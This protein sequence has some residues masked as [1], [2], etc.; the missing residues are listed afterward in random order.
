MQPFA[1]AKPPKQRVT[2]I[3]FDHPSVSDIALNEALITYLHSVG[4][5]ESAEMTKERQR[6]LTLLN[7]CIRRWGTEIWIKKGL[8][9]EKSHDTSPKLFAFGSYRLGVHDPNADLDTLCIIPQHIEREDFFSSLFDILRNE[10]QITSVIPVVNA[11]VPVMMLEICGISIDLT[12][13]R[14]QQTTIPQDL[15]LSHPNILLKCVD[16]T[17]R[18]SL[19]GPR[20]TDEILTL[21]PAVES[22]RMALR[23]IKRWAKSRAI[24]SNSLG[25]PGGVSWAML[26]AHI[27]QFYPNAAAATVLCKFFKM[28]T[29][30][31]WPSPVL[32]TDIQIGGQFGS[33]VWCQRNADKQALMPVITPTYPAFNST[34][35]ISL[36]T[37]SVLLKEFQRGFAITSAIEKGTM[38][39]SD[40]FEK[41]SFFHA[42]NVFIRINCIAPNKE[43]FNKLTGLV[44]SR[45]RFMVAKLDST[46][47]VSYAHPYSNHIG[48]KNDE[49]PT[50]ENCAY[51]LGLVYKEGVKQIT[52]TQ[53]VTF[54]KAK[55]EEHKAPSAEVTVQVLTKYQLPDWCFENGV[56][57][58]PP[59][60]KKR[61]PKAEP[62][63]ATNTATAPKKAK[64]AE[65]MN[66]DAPTHA[67]API[68]RP[69]DVALPLPVNNVNVESDSTDHV[70]VDPS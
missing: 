23:S 42:Y 8:P 4:T 3:T 14:L 55:V 21:V 27:C 6:V 28:Y 19:N 30:W 62:V 16:A 60:K 67:L 45:I 22:F 5:F 37:K 46:E 63:D 12:C 64:L 9:N 24:Y 59:T 70:Q 33:E 35:N 51:F 53:A 44:E 25:F 34:F 29:Q 11:K 17:D 52:I 69:L 1:N 2:P 61:K 20:V 65:E 57:P 32:L 66:I 31:P 54:F 7:D 36:S 47:G 15:N 13:A 48:Y 40:L 56:R 49:D 41:F 38:Q 39:W 26:T 68:Q 43:E 18:L 10:S 58:T 50:A